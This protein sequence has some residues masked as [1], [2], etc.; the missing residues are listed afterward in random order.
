MLDSDHTLLIEYKPFEPASYHTDIPDWGTAYS[1]A[2][3]TGVN[4]KVL[5]DLGHH[6]HGTNIEQIVATLLAENRLGG[7]HFNSRRYADDD[8]TSGSSNPYEL[9]LIFVELVKA[10]HDD[11]GKEIVYMI[12]E[13]H[14][15]K[16]PLEEM[17]QSLQ[18]LQAAYA[19]ALIVDYD[20]LDAAQS[21]NDLIAAEEII[22][23][24]FET[25][26]RPLLYHVREKMNIANPT[27]PIAH[28]RHSGYR[29]NCVKHRKGKASG[30]LGVSNET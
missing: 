6:F 20:S 23:D 30:G 13:G 3:A 18:S 8:L 29:E 2:L 7:F 15:L 12:D 28:F 4:A 24:A 26:I 11:I 10:E 9:F 5:V 16:D 19:K 21:V 22:K 25:D 14:T 27:D 1:L 17:I